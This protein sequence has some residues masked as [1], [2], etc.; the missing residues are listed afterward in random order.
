MKKI[1]VLV[2]NTEICKL[3]LKHCD[4]ERYFIIFGKNQSFMFFFHQSLGPQTYSFYVEQEGISRAMEII[5][6]CTNS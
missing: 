2:Q 6:Y 4:I 1:E 5:Y 3:F